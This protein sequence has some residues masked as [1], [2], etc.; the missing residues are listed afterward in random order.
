MA[1]T[2]Q[3]MA[4]KMSDSLQS[5]HRWESESTMTDGMGGFQQMHRESVS[6]TRNNVNSFQ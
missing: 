1:E 6:R 2:V 5:V 4:R 3:N